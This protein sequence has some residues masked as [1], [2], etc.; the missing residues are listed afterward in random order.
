MTKYISIL[1][2]INLGAHKKMAM[3]DLK[4]LY[5]NLG[6]TEVVTYI[7]SGNVVFNAPDDATDLVQKIEQAIAAK[8][9]FTVPVIVRKAE[10]WVK[11]VSK[12][13]FL[14][15]DGVDLE[16]MHVTFL[17]STPSDVLLEKIKLLDFSPDKFEILGQEVYLYCPI[18]Y[19]H[20]KLSNSFFE[21]KLKVTAT[22]RNWKTVNKLLELS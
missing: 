1:R 9:P 21:S 3:P 12:N 13:P 10:E 2:G 7:Q 8:Y 19:G 4:A 16:K 17:G 5:E 20:T 6:F 14:H 18:D 11:I 22:T 15:Q